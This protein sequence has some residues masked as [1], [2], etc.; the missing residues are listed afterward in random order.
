MRP[1]VIAAL[2]A[3]G[4]A[5][6][7]LVSAARAAR[8][9]FQF[10][11]QPGDK[12]L[13]CGLRVSEPALDLSFRFG[14][15]YSL[16]VPLEQFS[17]PNHQLV[18]LMRI[19][20]EGGA[21]VY[22]TSRFFLRLAPKTEA[23]F[24]ASAAYL[25]GQGKY[26]VE[27]IMYDERDRVCR[28]SWNIDAKLS[29]SERNIKPAI[30][31][32]TVAEIS[33]RGLPAG[34][35]VR[36]DGPPIRLTVLLQAAP[37]GV[38]RATL[39]FRDRILLLGTLSTL[40]NRVP[41]TSVRLVV[42]NLDQQR[43]L[44]RQEDFHL[45]AISDVSQA[46]SQLNLQKVDYGVL[47]NRT[48]AKDL[49][50]DLLQGEAESPK[51]SDAVVFLGPYTREATVTPDTGGLAGAAHF[52]YF[53]I[54]SPFAPSPIFPDLI[55]KAVARA[56]GRILPIRTPADFAAAMAQVERVGRAQ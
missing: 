36:D 4:A 35:S 12:R 23:T 27:W 49:L 44:Y 8:L 45:D 14:A 46:M 24:N 37:I 7:N 26:R 50:T 47:R 18:A 20:P 11:R 41:V 29:H 53:L 30:P 5:G 40:L 10:T 15:G 25:V 6:Q 22:L 51:P 32:G 16:E 55:A 56:K 34:S 39:R 2:L 21:A 28:R 48:G 52:F 13:A 42:F 1:L 19:T 31:P 43:E 38:G 9:N 3:S 54:R 17:G 33:G